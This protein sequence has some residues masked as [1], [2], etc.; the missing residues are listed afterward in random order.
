MDK[1]P[2][3]NIGYEKITGELEFLKKKE[4][5]ETV[6]AL[7]EARQL[8]D[9][10]ENAE[11]HSAKEKLALIDIQM[12]E[13]GAIISKAVIIDPTT[14]PHTKV[15]FGSTIEL[16]DVDTDEEFKYAIVG[17]VESNA[18]NG[19]ISFN[20]PLAKQLLGKEE[21]DE[22]KATLPGGIKTFEILSVG[23]KELKI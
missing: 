2:M 7:E 10:K 9:L 6:I 16:V 4:R 13:I 12:A 17:G 1:E 8:G 14:L 5:P 15:S 19:L 22:I 21:G 20:S 11:Y 23:Y 3:T 18:D